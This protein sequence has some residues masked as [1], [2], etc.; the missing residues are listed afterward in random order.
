[1]SKSSQGPSNQ[2]VKNALEDLVKSGAL[3]ADPIQREL[4]TQLD[5]IKDI[6]ENHKQGSKS[7]ALGWLFNKRKLPKGLKG[8]YIWGSVGRGKSMLMDLFYDNLDFQAKRRVHFHD[9]MGDAQERIHQHRQL[10]KAGKTKEEDPIKPVARQLASDAKVLCFDEFSVTDIADAMILGRLFQALFAAGVVIIATS[11]VEP[12]NLYK[13]GLNRQR[14]LPFIDLLKTYCDV[15][16]LDARTDYRLEKISKAP[17]YSAPLGKKSKLAMDEAWRAITGGK[18]NLKQTLKIKGREVVVPAVVE[19]S[20]RFSFSDLC[21]AP[22]G[23][24]DYLEIARNFNTVFIDNVPMMD[25]SQRNIA[26]R[27]INL[28]DTLYDKKIKVYISAASNPH[29]LY[30]GNRGVEAFEFGRTSSRLIEMQSKSYIEATS[31]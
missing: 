12:D 13:D 2:F 4:A 3:Q 9:F 31:R 25:F 27:F 20:A 15:F 11:N 7:S 18:K 30:V 24:Q 28:I 22:L 26:K 17:V 5:Q 29:A 19:K 10:L 6:L 1:M 21:E 16:K 8:L 14:F 23:S